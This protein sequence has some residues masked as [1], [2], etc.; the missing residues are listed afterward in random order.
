MSGWRTLL[1]AEWRKVTTTKM[2]WV[3]TLVAVALS[4]VN[5][6]PLILTASG[7]I[8]GTQLGTDLLADP[9]FITTALSQAGTAAMFALIL[10]VIAMTGE[11]RHMTIT[12]TFLV[13]PRRGRIVAVKMLLFGILGAAMAV[14]VTAAVTITVSVAL[15]PFEHAPV[16]AAAVGQVL[17][18]AVVGLA[19]YGVLGVAVGALLRSQVGAIIAAVLWILLLEPIVSALLPAVARWLPGGALS[20]AMDA[21]L[22]ADFTGSLSPADALPAWLAIAV[23]LGYAAVFAA[24]A[25]RTTVRRDIT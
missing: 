4:V 23:L 5:V 6:V 19:L 14:I 2:A 15:L 12:S 13:E 20:A 10:G 8:P 3:L 18:G 1:A 17:V 11:Y 16:T 21:G 7:T 24:V 22:R 9:A 25:S